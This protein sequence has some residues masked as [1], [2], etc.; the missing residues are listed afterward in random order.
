[1]PSVFMS[2]RVWVNESMSQ[3]VS[4]VTQTHLMKANPNRNLKL[5]LY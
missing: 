2:Q 4:A 3:R 1:M 5:L